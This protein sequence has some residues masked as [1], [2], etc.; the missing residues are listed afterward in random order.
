[1][2]IIIFLLSLFNSFKEGVIKLP[3]TFCQLAFSGE[4][5]RPSLY[6][7]KQNFQLNNC[8]IAKIPKKSH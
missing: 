8:A 6:K 1:M 4:P 2:I 3:P 5:S 7:N